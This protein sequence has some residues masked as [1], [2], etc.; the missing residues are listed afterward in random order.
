MA[1]V[2]QHK[3]LGE[4][5]QPFMEP[6]AKAGW[7]RLSDVLQQRDTQRQAQQYS[8]LLGQAM[9]KAEEMGV[10][11]NSPEGAAILTKEALGL[12]VPSNV[13]SDAFK[14]IGG[15][16]EGRALRKISYTLNSKYIHEVNKQGE[17]ASDIMSLLPD[18]KKAIESNKAPG[19]SILGQTLFKTNEKLFGKVPKEVQTLDSVRKNVILKLD[20]LKAK[21]VMTNQL[22]D[23]LV[24]SLWDENKSVDQNK[25]AL[26]ILEE[27]LN[28]MGGR[29]DLASSLLKDRPDSLYSPEF[30]LML[31]DQDVMGH[32]YEKEGKAAP[33]GQATEATEQSSE[34]QKTAS[35]G[36]EFEPTKGF[37][38]T[39]E[40]AKQYKG[41]RAR[42]A[43]GEIVQ[44]DGTGWQKIKE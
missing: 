6:I 28:L 37:N 10:D 21:G 7:S 2:I 31:S 8:T 9:Q 40:N 27:Q 24:S 26:R 18:V 36:D 30:Q 44:S 13:V 41:R 35:A 1:T 16:A 5:M 42:N 39:P 19:A 15:G 22:R 11:Y 29:K 23:F 25:E 17:V 3:G 12:G 34:K 20:N 43:K 33:T 14:N 4:L 32:L 38:P